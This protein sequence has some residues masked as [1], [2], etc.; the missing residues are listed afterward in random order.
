MDEKNS[1]T[2]RGFLSGFLVRVR[3]FFSTYA[4][5]VAILILGFIL[6]VVSDKFL[7]ITNLVNVLRQ[8]SMVAIMSVGAYFV[9]VSGGLDA[10]MGAIVGLS[11]IVCATLMV[12][13]SVPPAFAI[14]CAL[15]TGALAGLINGLTITRLNIPP[16]IATI[17]MKMILVGVA[18]IICQGYTI[19][20]IPDAIVQVGRGYA[21]H[22]KWLP[23]PVAIMLLVAIAADLVSQ[24]TKFGRY[25][26]AVGGNAEAAHLSG[27]RYKNI[28]MWSYILAGISAA[29]AGIIVTGRLTAGDAKS[30]DGWE[31]DAI[32][33]C[34]IGGVST[35][36]G[37][38]RVFGAVLGT[39]MIGLLNNGMTLLNIDS[40]Y[41]QVVSGVV[42]MAAIAFDIYNVSHTSRRH[43]IKASV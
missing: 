16:L 6:T 24:R 7:T 38:G 32:I 21:F 37:R 26:Y 17:G 10:S 8:V 39:I 27:I 9:I 28:Q 4:I 3:R 1:L 18:Y 35:T 36:G 14:L 42:L 13:L 33:A 22:L 34:V 30:G 2:Q 5:I 23:I 19:S 29:I 15:G 43:G 25:I 41:Q 12:K 31:F 11:S 40:Y 20:G